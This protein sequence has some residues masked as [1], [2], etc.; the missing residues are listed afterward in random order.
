MDDKIGRTRVYI[1]WENSCNCDAPSADSEAL[2]LAAGSSTLEVPSVPSPLAST[3]CFL[4]VFAAFFLSVGAAFALL[5]DAKQQH[6]FS[7]QF[8]KQMGRQLSEKGNLR[9]SV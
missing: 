1:T 9:G 4:P 5:H 3:V 2:L 6:L 7:P 8:N